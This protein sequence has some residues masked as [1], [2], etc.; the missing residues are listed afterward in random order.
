MPYVTV[1][2][3][4]SADINLHYNDHGSGKPIV[5]IH[6]YPLEGN[7]WEKQEPELLE[8]G[9]RVISYD[10]RGF[11]KSSQPITGYDYDTF[12]ADLKA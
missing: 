12:A 3:E 11:G 4:N 6:G 2:T 5:L 1:G 7:S 8:A 10:R 9:W